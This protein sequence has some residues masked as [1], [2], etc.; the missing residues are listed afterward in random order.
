MPLIHLCRERGC[1]TLTMG[2]RCLDHE[3]LAE[4]RIPARITGVF[5]RLRAP[6]IAL[7]FAVFA[8]FIGRASA[9]FGS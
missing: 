9:R 5:D 1:E 3:R 7:A 4:A 8:A 2:E 6:A